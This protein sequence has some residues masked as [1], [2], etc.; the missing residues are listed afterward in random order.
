MNQ[1]ENQNPE[2]TARAKEAVQHTDEM[3]KRY[4]AEIAACIKQSVIYDETYNTMPQGEY[5]ISVENKDSVTT[6]LEGGLKKQCVLNFASYTNPGGGFLS[7]SIAQE[8]ALCHES[9]LHNVISQ[10]EEAFYQKNIKDKNSC[11]YKNRCIYSPDVI[12]T[13]GSQAA[14]A[15]VIT[16]AS[17]NWKNAEKI[18]ISKTVNNAA[19]RMRINY[20]LNI[21]AMHKPERI[22]LGAFG[23]GVFGQNPETVAKLFHEEINRVFHN[24]K[25][26]IVF[27]IPMG[28]GNFEVFLK[29]M[30]MR[31]QIICN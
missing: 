6:I 3:N 23:C 1:K 28:N 8:E 21:I 5:T 7:G 29:E 22:I 12:F 16:C 14:R 19:L 26:E 17:P 30:D 2:K 25:A 18:G 4:N 27:A 15:D 11:L 20:I 13:R 9:F 31:K 24:R 10:M